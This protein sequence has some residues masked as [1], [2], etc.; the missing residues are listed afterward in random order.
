MALKKKPEEHENHERWLVSYADFITLLFAFFVVMYSVSSLNEGKYRVASESMMAAFSN[1]KPLGQMSVMKL[2][3]EKSRAAM[4]SK[5]TV[6]PDAFQVY[7]KASNSIE[8]IALSKKGVAVQNTARGISIQIK[9]DVLFDGGSTEIKPAVR[10]LLDLIAALVKD[11]PNLI[12]IEGH[13]DAVPIHTAAFPSNWELSATRA[14]TLVRYLI[15][16]HHLAP[17]RFAA[18]GFGGERPI[19]SNDTPEGRSAN[20]RVDIVIL[21]ETEVPIDQGRLTLY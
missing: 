9:D 13:T 18:I 5:L 12:S 21:R 14:T 15:N 3:M 2:P 6:R 11:L 1:Q 17:E 10:E 16:Q 4:D 19:A 8:S 20:R 7:L